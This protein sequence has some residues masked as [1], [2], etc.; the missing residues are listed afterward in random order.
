[1]T[2]ESRAGRERLFW[3]ALPVVTFVLFAVASRTPYFLLFRLVFTTGLVLIG[4]SEWRSKGRGSLPTLSWAVPVG[5]LWILAESM[6][7]RPLLAAIV[8]YWAGGGLVFLMSASDTAAR[9]WYGAVL[10][11]PFKT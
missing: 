5:L 8:M 7:D 6:F 11:R 9:W 1:M 10:R 4:A 2:G 3:L